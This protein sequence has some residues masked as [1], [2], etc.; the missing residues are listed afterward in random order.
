MTDAALPVTQRAVEEFSEKYL[1]TLGCDIC[2]K[3]DRWN[4]TVPS[5]AETSVATG[6]LTLVC[7]ADSDEAGDEEP[8][9]P[10]SPFFYTLLDE[11]ADRWPTGR[12][13]ITAA[14][15]E[16]ILPAWIVNSD[17]S[18]ESANFTPYYDRTALVVLFQV[19][20]ETVSEYQTELLRA[21]AID[22][23]SE[24]ILPRVA[25]TVLMRTKPDRKSTEGETPTISPTDGRQLVDSVREAVVDDIQ[26]KI[27]EI[28]EAASRS[29]DA[30]IEEYRQLQQQRIEELEQ[31]KADL[32]S[33]IDDIREVLEGN[34]DQSD[35]A[36]ALKQR[37][38]LRSELE[39]V[40]GELEDLCQRR[41]RGFPR[42]RREIRDRHAL[43]VV[44]EPITLTE[45]AYER[46]EIDI[47]LTD[48]K[49]SHTLTVGYGSG[50]GVTEVVECESCGQPLSEGD[51][52]CLAT[53]SIY[54]SSCVR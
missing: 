4:V 49:E 7:S 21:S 25:E 15:T 36:E 18:V 34:D 39:N 24:E 38:E 37:R 14:D 16:I 48:G 53:G 45:V 3:D 13:E 22:I 31:Q 35:R 28:H 29:A 51:P 27:E 23:R 41:E 50:I 8:L 42:K 6:E 47:S 9:N 33:R 10:E 17:A 1:K 40:E 19:S 5:D 26:S 20:I 2:K 32:E 43:E 52:L 46:G 12:I 54:C 30:E 11:A 44:I